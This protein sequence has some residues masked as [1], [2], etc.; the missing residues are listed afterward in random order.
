MNFRKIN[1]LHYLLMALAGVVAVYVYFFSFLNS[2]YAPYYGDEHFYFKN[3]EGFYIT[4]NLKAIFTY[5]GVGSRVFGVDAHGPAYP[6]IYGTISKLIGW[7]GISIPLINIS[8][9]LIAVITLILSKGNSASVKVFQALLILGSPITLFYSVT[10]LPELL[11][12]AGAIG[13]FLLTK[14]YLKSTKPIDL[15]ILLVF[16]LLLGSIR[17]TW[18]FALYG[19]I[20]LPRPNNCNLKPVYLILGIALPFLFQY[21]FH[22]QVP[23][24]FSGINEKIQEQEYW[25]ALNTLVFNLKRNIYFALYY[26]EGHF[27]T[28]QKIWVAASLLYSILYYRKDKVMMGGVVVLLIIIIFNLILYKNYTWVDLRMYTPICLFLNLGIISNPKHRWSAETF[29]GINLASFV[30]ILPFQNTLISYRVNPETCEIPIEITEKIETMHTTLVQIDSVI[31]HSY[32]ISQLPIQA[33]NGEVIR[34]VLPYY[35]M[36]MLPPSHIIEE[37]NGQLSVRSTNILNQ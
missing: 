4:N 32:S 12:L 5:S 33:K 15:L 6:L 9:L 18:F 22:E 37:K 11:Q 26:T 17:T 27:Y 3:S 21:F 28:L 8:V 7:G 2:N 36:N 31:L 10:Y 30:L 16:I 14:N 24:T 1:K 13:L 34:Y 29:V 23:N 20:M 25:K 19:V 35:E